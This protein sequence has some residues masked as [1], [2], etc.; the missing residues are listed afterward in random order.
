MIATFL[1]AAAFQLQFTA[2]KIDDQIVFN[3]KVIERASGKIVAA[4]RLESVVKVPAE[5]RTTVGGTEFR[6]RAI[7]RADGCAEVSLDVARDGENIQ[8]T[9]LVGRTGGKF[10]GEPISLNLVDA[11]IKDVLHTFSQLTGISMAIDPDVK[12]TVT[13]ELHDVPWDQALD[14]ILRQHKLGATF[15]GGVL[16]VLP[17]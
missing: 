10:T 15:E 11:D 6:I 7:S 3:V 17:R 2:Q 8:H 13:L 4:P 1:L 16:R 9:L 5:M 12:G 14:L